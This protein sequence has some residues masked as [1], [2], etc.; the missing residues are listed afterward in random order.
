MGLPSYLID[1]VGD[2]IKGL[3]SGGKASHKPVRRNMGGMMGA[4]SNTADS[5]QQAN[6]ILSNAASNGVGLK[7]GGQAHP[8]MRHKHADG[9]AMNAMGQRDFDAGKKA[10][11]FNHGGSAESHCSDRVKRAV[12][13]AG[14][15][16]H[17]QMTRGGAQIAPRCRHKG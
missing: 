9:G 5:I 7:R 6:Q 2:A 15:I 3:K 14:K 1:G 10:M 8:R 17:G 13:G 4:P 11:G 16:R 12:G